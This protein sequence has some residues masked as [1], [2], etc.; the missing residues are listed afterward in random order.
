MMLLKGMLRFTFGHV[1]VEKID[2]F[3]TEFEAIQ[4]IFNKDVIEKFKACE[5]VPDQ[6]LIYEN[7]MNLSELKK[8]M[9]PE[10]QKE[11]EESVSEYQEKIKGSKYFKEY[12]EMIVTFFEEFQ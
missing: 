10:E 4:R 5:S 8:D 12:L 6:K 11:V 2:K 9:D 1:L 3:S 7:D